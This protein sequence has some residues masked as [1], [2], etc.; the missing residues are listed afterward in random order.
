MA[1]GKA[2]KMQFCN[3]KPSRAMIDYWYYLMQLLQ[4]NFFATT[5][6]ILKMFEAANAVLYQELDFWNERQNL[7][8]RDGECF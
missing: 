5:N 8:K 6:T 3:H 1:I 2:K 7:Y 4:I